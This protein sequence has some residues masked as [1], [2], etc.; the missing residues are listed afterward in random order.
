MMHEIISKKTGK[1]EI[2]SD[3]VW[4][5]VVARGWAKKYNHTELPE[6]KLR[7]VPII[8]AEIKTKTTKK[9]TNG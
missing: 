3:E 8:P 5:D 2:V 1:I 7:E 9:V 4:A 6:R